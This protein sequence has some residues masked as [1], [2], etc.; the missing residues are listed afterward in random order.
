MMLS[1]RTMI[2]FSEEGVRT[3]VYLCEEPECDIIIATEV[4]PVSKRY[5]HRHDR[6]SE[7]GRVKARKAYYDSRHR[8]VAN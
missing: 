6:R 3:L 4:Y 1:N 2:V 7:A 5:C 8:S